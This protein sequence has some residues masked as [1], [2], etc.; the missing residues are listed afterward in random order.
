MTSTPKQS[1]PRL[2][3]FSSN[4]HERMKLREFFA[5]AGYEI[6]EASEYACLERIMRREKV[7]LLILDLARPEADGASVLGRL[8]TQGEQLPIITLIPRDEPVDRI[9][10]LQEGADDC[11][12]KPFAFR[13]LEARLET[14]LRRSPLTYLRDPVMQKNTVMLGDAIIDLSARKLRRNGVAHA[15][16]TKEFDLLRTFLSYPNRPMTRGRLLNLAH[17]SDDQTGLRSID[18][19]VSRLRKVIEPD[20]SKPRYLQTVWGSGYVFVP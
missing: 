6:R 10:S 14:V 7:D 12:S 20:C 11:L 18:V 5:S 2:L 1:L 19:Q 15:I 17:E 4:L 9:L 13:E 16:S 8:R 3:L